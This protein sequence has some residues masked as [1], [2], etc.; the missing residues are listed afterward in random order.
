MCQ[1]LKIFHK[2]NYCFVQVVKST[3]CLQSSI[4]TEIGNLPSKLGKEWLTFRH[5]TTFGG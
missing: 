4:V 3:S 5:W 2:T 1:C